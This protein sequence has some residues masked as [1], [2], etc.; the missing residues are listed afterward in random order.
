MP[1]CVNLGAGLLVEVQQRARA[2]P[3]ALQRF[4][5]IFDLQTVA[6]RGGK[7]LPLWSLR[8]E[9]V[10]PQGRARPVKPVPMNHKLLGRVK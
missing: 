1:P 2:D 9:I 3:C 7:P 5:N 4:D 10:E 6:G 8:R